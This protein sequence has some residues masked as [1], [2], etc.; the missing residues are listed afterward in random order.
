V[1]HTHSS[2]VKTA[3]LCWFIYNFYKCSVCRR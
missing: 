3:D 2:N 1:K